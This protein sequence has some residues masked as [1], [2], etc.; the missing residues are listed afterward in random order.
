MD[1]LISIIIP[2]YNVE[3]YL[4]KCLDSLIGQTYENIEL[5]LVN[6]GATDR[7]LRIA[8]RYA[9]NYRQIKLVTQKNGGLSK[10]RNTGMKLADGEYLCFVDSDDWLELDTIQEIV[11]LM[12]GD[13]LDLCLFGANGFLSDRNGLQRQFEGDYCYSSKCKGIYLGKELFSKLYFAGEFKASACLYMMKRRL[14]EENRLEFKEGMIHEDDL[15]TPFL[16]YYAGRA[17]LTQKK[18]YNRRLRRN[19][20]VTGTK[21]LEHMKGYGTAFLG[22]VECPGNKDENHIVAESYCQLCKDNLQQSLNYYVLLTNQE[23]KK[24]K[25]LI[26]EIWKE[27]KGRKISLPFVYYAF[28]LKEYITKRGRKRCI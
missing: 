13:D 8:E 18:F 1:L 2:I 6:D 28:L 11:S 24:A 10:A 9:E 20:I 21:D 4:E 3:E 12:E 5:I 26:K 25:A 19:S 23:K 15:F 17:E 22:L 7:S 14:I 27:K 16:F